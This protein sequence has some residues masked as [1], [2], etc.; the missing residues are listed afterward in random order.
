MGGTQGQRRFPDRPLRRTSPCGGSASPGARWSGRASGLTR[1]S[2]SSR[3]LHRTGPG[4]MPA[5]RP[6]RPLPD[7]QSKPLRPI[8]FASR[9]MISQS[10]FD[11]PGPST[12]FRTRLTRLSPL[13][14]VPSFSA[15]QVPGRTTSAYSQALV[16]EDILHNTEIEFVKLSLHVVGVRVGDYGV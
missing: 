13:V 11:S 3:R 15:K 14:N 5:C 8:F 9:P 10:Y 16:P 1:A 2:P 7:F 6:R 12:A 4:C